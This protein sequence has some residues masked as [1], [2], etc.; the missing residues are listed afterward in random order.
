MRLFRLFTILLP[1]FLVFAMTVSPVMA[2]EK[3]AKAKKKDQGRYVNLAV[4]DIEAIR[5]RAK[6]V[7]NI[8]KQIGKY[9][10]SF[11]D[12]I[13]KEEEKLR[14]ANQELERK[15][16]IMSP[17]AFGEERKKFEENF[18]NVQRMVQIRKRKLDQ[19][20]FE[21]MRK[22]E[23]KL[24]AIVTDLAKKNNL[25]L[26]LRRSQTVLVT[27]ILSITN[28]VLKEIDKDMPTL[29]VPDL[30]KAIKEQSKKAAPA[31]GK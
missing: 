28:E 8:R 30:E 1:V 25:N 22:V 3:G 7:K 9:Q 17:E 21:A 20:Q 11:R 4:I 19:A 6:V 18:L 14:K 26:I 15:R 31:K 2:Q 16:T 27:P 13:Q 23:L 29:K 5:Q 10:V 24:N 12:A